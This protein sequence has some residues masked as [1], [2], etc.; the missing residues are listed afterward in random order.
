MATTT[1]T[2]VVETRTRPGQCPTHGPVIATKSIPKLR[3]PFVVWLV[4]R[5]IAL[6]GPYRCPTCG[7][8][9]K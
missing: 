7:Q 4:R 8:A 5:W 6:G 2:T 9:T 3:F 1:T